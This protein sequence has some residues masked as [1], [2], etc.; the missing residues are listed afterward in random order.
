MRST[1]AVVTTIAAIAVTSGSS[2]G[3]QQG[4][5][6]DRERLPYAPRQAICYRTPKPLTIDGRLDEPAWRETAWSDPFIDIQGEAAPRF[7]TRV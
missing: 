1:A 6:P 7:R 3:L 5:E 2:L 4:P